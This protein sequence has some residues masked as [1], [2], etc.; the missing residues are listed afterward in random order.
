M[1]NYG[2]MTIVN[3]YKNS[4]YY[5]TYLQVRKGDVETCQGAREKGAGAAAA[6]RR[7]ESEDAPSIQG[8]STQDPAQAEEELCEKEEDGEGERGTE[9]G[10]HG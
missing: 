7:K 2:H 10:S 5:T 1:N 8:E 4:K 6:G 9:D 3:L